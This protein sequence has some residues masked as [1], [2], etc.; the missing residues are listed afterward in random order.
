MLR[1]LCTR[2]WRISPASAVRENMK[3][4]DNRVIADCEIIEQT[5]IG[6]HVFRSVLVEPTIARASKPGQ[7]V[8]V[9]VCGCYDP[10]L[11]RPFSVH[12]V[13]PEKGTFALLY[14]VIGRGTKLLMDMR[15]GDK[16]NVVGPLGSSFDV[17]EDS[18]AYH[19]L[20]AGGCGAA[21]IHFLSDT[22]CRK[23]SCNNVTVLVGARTGEA[24]LCEREFRAHGV[25]VEVATDDGSYGFKGL[26][27]D[28][29]RECLSNPQPPTPESTPAARR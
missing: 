2:D 18:N 10:L 20:V 28:L 19:I 27:T 24:V 17:G 15:V 4:Q 6:P 21:P 1:V 7:F 12:A 9:R 23:H 11:R 22:I 8:N 25:K 16:V 3:T 29:L 14:D 13:D 26:V 5:E